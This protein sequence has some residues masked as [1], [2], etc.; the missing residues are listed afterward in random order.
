V[1]VA[2]ILLR[3]EPAEGQQTVEV[4]GFFVPG[5]DNKF[6]IHVGDRDLFNLTH[7]PTGM[8][9]VQDVTKT[10]AIWLARQLFTA[11]PHAWSL[12]DGDA[13]MEALPFWARK[14]AASIRSA[15]EDG[16]FIYLLK[17]CADFV[18]E[19]EALDNKQEKGDQECP[20]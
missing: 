7:V 9:S 17:S 8:A 18:R 6:A 10:E 2:K 15:A 5:T 14:W 19:M 11:C 16:E 13:V 3:I 1:L 4:E 12:E 20:Q